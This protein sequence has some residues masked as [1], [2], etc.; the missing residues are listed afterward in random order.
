MIDRSE[1][2]KLLQDHR[3]EITSY[4]VKSLVL[5]GSVARDEADQESDI[6][7]LVEFLQPV[8][9]FRFIELKQYL[10]ALLN[11]RVDLGTPRSLGPHSKSTAIRDAIYVV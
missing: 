8:G 3:A 6:D 2:I 1:A 10:E 5:F 9:L 7:L 11:T 4:G